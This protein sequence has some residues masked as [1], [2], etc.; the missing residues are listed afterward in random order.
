[1]SKSLKKFHSLQVRREALVGVCRIWVHPEFQRRGFAS[2]LVDGM[3]GA[4]RLPMVVKRDEVAFSHTTEMGARFAESYVG[5][6]E[7]YV[8]RPGG[9]AEA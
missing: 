9:G 4:Y 1:M 3:R 6:K 8:Y 5:R 7:F 2:R